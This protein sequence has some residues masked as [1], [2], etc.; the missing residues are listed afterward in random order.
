MIL[1]VEHRNLYY[2]YPLGLLN[3]Q[4]ISKSFEGNTLIIFKE[5]AFLILTSIVLSRD[6]STHNFS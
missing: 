2:L 4:D 3:C 5:I 1:S 6:F